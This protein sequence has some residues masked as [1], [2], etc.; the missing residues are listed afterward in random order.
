MNHSSKT[1][2]TLVKLVI[3]YK[4]FAK[5]KTKALFG[6]KLLLMLSTIMVPFIRGS[7][8]CW[9][10]WV[11]LS[12]SLCLI[13]ILKHGKSF[14]ILESTPFLK[15]FA[16]LFVSVWGVVVI[17]ISWTNLCWSRGIGDWVIKWRCFHCISGRCIWYLRLGWGIC[18]SLWSLSSPQA[19][20]LNT[21]LLLSALRRSL[22]FVPNNLRSSGRRNDSCV[23]LFA[24]YAECT[25]F[26]WH[27]ATVP[28]MVD[29][30]LFR[31]LHFQ[32]VMWVNHIS[33]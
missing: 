3:M 23:V 25:A 15:V 7:A 20:L 26:T 31:K 5:R 13:R 28:V 24:R 33:P 4:S 29:R 1:R 16:V 10:Y 11:I 22:T 8:L 12:S 32:V 18:S 19:M 6:M 30:D 2:S 9:T 14:D 17:A 21:A 27:T